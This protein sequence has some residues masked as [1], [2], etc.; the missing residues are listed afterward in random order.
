MLLKLQIRKKRFE[1]KPINNLI[2]DLESGTK[3]TAD[4]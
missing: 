4:R 3:H 1:K 2:K